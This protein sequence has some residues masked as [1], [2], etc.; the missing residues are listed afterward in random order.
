MLQEL[1]TKI[2]ERVDSSS[3]IIINRVIKKILD[4]DI[5]GT[6]EVYT[7]G[8]NCDYCRTL[9]QYTNGKILLHHLQKMDARYWAN[10]ENYNY[11]QSIQ[12]YYKA[13][14]IG[15]DSFNRP[16]MSKFS[17]GDSIWD[18]NRQL[19]GLK[20]RKDRLLEQG[21]CTKRN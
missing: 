9:I 2:K 3:D 1:Q 11:K 18:V 10:K 20:Q 12:R 7:S 21:G 13:V 6:R 4:G 5:I 16:I 17:I 8:C 19:E 15:Y 14:C